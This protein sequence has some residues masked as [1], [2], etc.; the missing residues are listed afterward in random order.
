MTKQEFI[1]SILSMRVEVQNGESVLEAFERQLNGVIRPKPL[2]WEKTDFGWVARHGFGKYLITLQD[3]GW[4][5]AESEHE[6]NFFSTIE[7]GK[8]W[9]EKDYQERFNQMLK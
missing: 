6:T 4:T 1:K 9:C 2:E 7:D 3:D 8:K 5:L